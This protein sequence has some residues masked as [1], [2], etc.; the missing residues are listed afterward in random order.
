MIKPSSPFLSLWRF[1]F[2]NLLVVLIVALSMLVLLYANLLVKSVDSS[3]TKIARFFEKTTILSFQSSTPDLIKDEIRES[4]LEIDS[5]AQISE[6]AS[7]PISF[8][9]LAVEVYSFV[10]FLEVSDYDSFMQNQGWELIQG[11]LPE[12]GTN[13]VAL[14]EDMMKNRDF[15]IG[16]E[17][18]NTV[19]STDYLA[20]SFE[21]V[22]I[23]SA[24]D[25]NGGIG[26]FS[27]EL[28]VLDS[29][30]FFV[31]IEDASNSD[32]ERIQSL[33]DEYDGLVVQDSSFFE[34]RFARSVDQLTT[35]LWS[36]NIV[37]A[38]AI[39]LSLSLFIYIMYGSR[40]KE[41]GAFLAVGYTKK[42][43]RRKLLLENIVMSV[44][45]Y[46][47]GIRISTILTRVANNAL[48]EPR[49]LTPF[50][51]SLFPTFTMDIFSVIFAM[52]IP[53]TFF[54]AS[55]VLSYIFINRLNLLKIINSR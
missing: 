43:L 19:D 22:G 51:V 20:G 34:R 42:D 2:K 5:N 33:A 49:G 25:T 40:T 31:K 50:E 46:I 6:G 11:K 8:Y 55:Y 38:V 7:S 15:S 3:G 13:Q 27:K 37:I 47:T 23:L 35:F 10:S 48:V 39:S 54:V 44:I 41:F 1:K 29:D 53:V 52:I 30:T 32:V 18:G 26:N 36:L 45:A 16:D 12:E 17:I 21:V 14:T 4:V 9:G 28:G 24:N